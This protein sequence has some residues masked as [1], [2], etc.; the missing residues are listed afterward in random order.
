[1]QATI[2]LRTDAPADRLSRCRAGEEQAW[3]QLLGEVRPL[4][5]TIAGCDFGLGPEDREDVFQLVSLKLY[6]NL[7][8]LRESAA[9]RPWLRSLTRRVIVDFLRGRK[10]AVSLD[11]L[12]EE[13]GLEPTEGTANLLWVDQATMRVEIERALETLPELYR[14]PV[15]LHVLEGEPQEEVSR[16]LG[17]PRNTVASQI[18]RGLA[19]LRRSLASLEYA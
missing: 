4:V 9:F 8:Q 7:R 2:E 15:A 13:C 16:R 3:E 14:L 1:M 10:D 11:Q 19:R 18:H 12:Q 6:E 17:R 5:H